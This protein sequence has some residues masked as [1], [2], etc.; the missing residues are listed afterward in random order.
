[1]RLRNEPQSLSTCGARSSCRES[2]SGSC[3]LSLLQL[4]LSSA[5]DGRAPRE[6][7]ARRNHRNLCVPRGRR[8]GR[9]RSGRRPSL[10]PYPPLSPKPP[11]RSPYPPR[12]SPYRS[13][14]GGARRSDPQLEDMS[15]RDG[16]VLR[17]SLCRR[18]RRRLVRTDPVD[19]R[20]ITSIA[21]PIAAV[22]AIEPTAESFIARLVVRSRARPRRKHDFVDVKNGRRPPDRRVAPD[23][24][25]PPPAPPA[26]P[27]ARA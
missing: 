25:P 2:R 3:F 12:L 23:D 5:R 15:A 26:I 17:D 13:S 24:P 11:R 22:P 8:S 27:R 4:S 6:A 10:S 16:L 7:D 21:V 14:A 1:M 18:T 20:R 19:A 9:R